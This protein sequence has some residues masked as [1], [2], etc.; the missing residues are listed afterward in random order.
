MFG[1]TSTNSWK[2]LRWVML[3]NCCKDNDV[4]K[5][6]TLTVKDG[7]SL[8]SSPAVFTNQDILACF[9][10][11]GQSHELADQLAKDTK[12][13]DKEQDQVSQQANF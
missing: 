1:C 4:S 3:C 9:H 2:K 10:H 13:S 11:S 12:K 7:A 6:A 8:F 5:A